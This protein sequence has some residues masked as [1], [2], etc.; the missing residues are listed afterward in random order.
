M[1]VPVDE[2]EASTQSSFVDQP[3]RPTLLRVSSSAS[4][5]PNSRKDNDNGFE[6]SSRML[7]G[8]RNATGFRYLPG[9]GSWQ[10]LTAP[11]P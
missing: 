8:K 2:D 3:T 4:I 10:T 11:N 1:P 9:R 6:N 7:S 5:F